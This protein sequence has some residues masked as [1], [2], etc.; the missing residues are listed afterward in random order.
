MPKVKGSTMS[1]TAIIAIC[2]AAYG[3]ASEIIGSSKKLKR[4]TTIGVIM[5]FFGY[6][7]GKK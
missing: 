7:F 6:I 5:D 4:N 1:A 3:L 2:T